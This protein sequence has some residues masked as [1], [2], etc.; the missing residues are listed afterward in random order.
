MHIL[1]PT[2]AN[3]PIRT[4]R[5]GSAQRSRTTRNA[6]LGL[7]ASA[8][9]ARGPWPEA[10]SLQPEA[11]SLK[12]HPMTPKKTLVVIGNGMVGHRF[13]EKLIEFDQAGQYRVVTF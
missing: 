4:A 11:C 12:D 8:V 1:I 2:P 7:Q 9:E 10:R 3:P 6:G 5:C 13:V